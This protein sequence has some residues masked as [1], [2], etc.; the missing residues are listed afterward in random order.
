MRRVGAPSGRMTDG[1]G[2]SGP[3]RLAPMLGFL[4]AWLFFV[5]TLAAALAAGLGFLLAWLFFPPPLPGGL[6]GGLWV[7][8]RREPAVDWDRFM[9]DLEFWAA[10]HGG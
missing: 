8:R 2:P 5:L 6:A 9:A 10:T 1:I 7:P 4:L 3:P